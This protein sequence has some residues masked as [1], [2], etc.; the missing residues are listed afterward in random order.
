MKELTFS[1]KNKEYKVC[2]THSDLAETSIINLIASTTETKDYKF[3]SNVIKN[4]AESLLIGLQHYHFD[5]FGYDS[6]DEK[7]KKITAIYSLLDDYGDDSTPENPKN[8]FSL[9][10]MVSKLLEET[11]FISGMFSVADPEA[12]PAS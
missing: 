11:N 1:V 7:R 3:L 9:Y 8:T 4:F 2:F 12:F 10:M 6:E 5:E